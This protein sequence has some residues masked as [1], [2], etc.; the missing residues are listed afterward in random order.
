MPVLE[1]SQILFNF[2]IS[3]AVVVITIFISLIAV[4]AIKLLKT[5]RKFLES[6]LN[7]SIVSKFF[8]KKNK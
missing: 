4:D 8:K 3:S 7:L 2:I 6:V 5:V 1:A